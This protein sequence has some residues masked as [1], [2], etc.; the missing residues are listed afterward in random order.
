MKPFTVEKD[1]V[2]Y[3]CVSFLTNRNRKYHFKEVIFFS[4]FRVSCIRS[5][6]DHCP[7]CW[8]PLSTVPAKTDNSTLCV[9]LFLYYLCNSFVRANLSLLWLTSLCLGQNRVNL[10]VLSQLMKWR[11][12]LQ[13][14]TQH[15]C[16][17][18]C[19]TF[20]P[21]YCFALES[22]DCFDNLSLFSMGEHHQ[23]RWRNM[24]CLSLYS[25]RQPFWFWINLCNQN[26]S[27]EAQ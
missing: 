21:F 8:S 22:F 14:G 18:S 17:T 16:V 25:A 6:L 20:D 24:T 19:P 1:G 5:S 13:W 3:F 10:F 2:I 9:L 26:D 12:K 15:V 27:F 11:F 4:V 23:T 7:W